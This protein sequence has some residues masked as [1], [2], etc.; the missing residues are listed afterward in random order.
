MNIEILKDVQRK[1]IE[2]RNKDVIYSIE[3]VMK[4][5][6]DIQLTQANIEHIAYELKSSVT[7]NPLLGEYKYEVRINIKDIMFSYYYK[8][9]KKYQL[10][11]NQDLF[12]SLIKQSSSYN[13]IIDL[14]LENFKDSEICLTLETKD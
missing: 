9:G 6:L 11:H 10:I 5:A 2:Y 8:N 14:L 4:Q 13:K 3:Y 7:D 12:K 1:A